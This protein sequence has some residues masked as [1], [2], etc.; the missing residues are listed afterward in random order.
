MATPTNVKK[1]SKFETDYQQR[2]IYRYRYLENRNVNHMFDTY[3]ENLTHNNAEWLDDPKLKYE[4][5]QNFSQQ[6]HWQHYDNQ[7]CS[8]TQF[9]KPSHSSNHLT[10]HRSRWKLYGQEMTS[11]NTQSSLLQQRRN[12]IEALFTV[13][14]NILSSYIENELYFHFYTQNNVLQIQ[15]QHQKLINEQQTLLADMDENDQTRFQSEEYLQEL[16]NQLKTFE[17]AID[18]LYHMNPLTL[19]HA[20]Y[21]LNRLRREIDRLRARLP[22]YAC[23]QRLIETIKNHQVIILKADTGSGKSSQLVQYLADAGFANHGLFLS[24]SP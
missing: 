20:Q 2:Q 9:Q 4:N 11:S 16:R 22:I 18:H 1:Y 10:T 14:I 17:Q 15:E 7:R 6:S 5:Q 13:R 8:Y 12:E 21:L 23:H 24:D 3:Q 19:N